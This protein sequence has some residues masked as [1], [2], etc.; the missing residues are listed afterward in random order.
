MG[1]E[2]YECASFAQE[3]CD[4]P[5]LIARLDGVNSEGKQLAAAQSA[6]DQHRDHRVIPLQVRQPIEE[7]PRL[8]AKTL[9]EWLQRERPGRFADGQ[10]RTLQ[11]RTKL[12]RATEG[13][14]QQVYFGQKHTP[15]SAR[16]FGSTGRAFVVNSTES[17]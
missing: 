10:I 11:R 8:E 12:W 16:G 13:P 3:V 4:N 5:M 1:L 15:G 14:T 2:R 17:A 6:S 7:S 9:F